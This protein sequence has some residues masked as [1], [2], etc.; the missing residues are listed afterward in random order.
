MKKCPYCAEEIQE[1]AAFCRYCHK[2]VK[3]IFFR[4][5]LLFIII[6]GIMG[7]AVFYRED[8]GRFAGDA[9]SFLKELGE[10]WKVAADNIKRIPQAAKT[11]EREQELIEKLLKEK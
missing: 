7:L 11:Y 9:K 6:A 10:V 8:I 4:R 2:K 1:E 5:A 3:G